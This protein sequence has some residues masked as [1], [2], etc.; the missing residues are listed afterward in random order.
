MM[1][2]RRGYRPVREIAQFFRE[3][4]ETFGRFERYV[5][6]M[7]ATMPVHSKNTIRPEFNVKSAKT[8]RILIREP[9]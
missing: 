5:D 1:V 9:R 7:Y 4:G 2:N 8:R 3:F 6:E